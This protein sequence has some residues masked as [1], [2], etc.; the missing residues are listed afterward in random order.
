M[1][2]KLKSAITLCLV[3]IIMISMCPFVH[4]QQQKVIRVGWPIQKG[5]TEKNRGWV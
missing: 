5:L 1:K 2:Q 3:A 4:A